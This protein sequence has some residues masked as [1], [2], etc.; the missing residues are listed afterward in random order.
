[1][2]APLPGASPAPKTLPRTTK[3]RVN[4]K[5]LWHMLMW[6]LGGDGVGGGQWAS[7]VGVVRIVATLVE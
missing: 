2:G 6:W 3:L 4:W 1:M 7:P 5:V